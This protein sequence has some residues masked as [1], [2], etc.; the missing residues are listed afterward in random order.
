MTEAPAHAKLSPSSAEKWLNCTAAPALEATMPEEEESVYA[1]EGT[2]WHEW[3][4]HELNFRLGKIKKATRTRRLNKLR[5]SE[6]GQ[7]FYSLDGVR[8]VEY[9]ADLV[10]EEIADMG[11]DFLY[12]MVEVRVDLSQWIPG[13][14]GTSDVI[15]V[16]S[17]DLRVVDLKMG[18][19]IAVSAFEN[20]QQMCYGLGA[21]EEL[22]LL[23]DIE[24]VR[25]VI[26]QPRRSNVSSYEMTAEALRAWGEDVVKPRALAADTG[27]GAVFDPS[28]SA[29]QWCK[30]KA[31][32]GARRDAVLAEEFGEEPGSERLGLEE[33]GEVLHRLPHLKKW[34]SDVEDYAKERAEAGEKVPG[35]KLVRGRANRKITDVEKARERLSEA[36]YLP[37]EYMKPQELK[38]LGQLE[39]LGHNVLETIGDALT[40][41]EG[42]PQL[43]PE[44]DK[45]EEIGTKAD[46]AADFAEFENDDEG[47]DLLG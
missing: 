14:F 42:A 30:A 43:A 27:E 33:I 37:V 21:L 41:P 13:S 31:V 12:A 15:L 47:D 39:K 23:G 28:L 3:G 44:D 17:H 9:Y 10:M 34:I 5:E 22:D 46:A 16:G 19:G 29:C 4:E 45:R 2:F 6:A 38:P 18:Q 8:Y 35:W 24:R 40:K 11:D 7:E 26:I 32:C 36:G 25:M 1:A 20:P